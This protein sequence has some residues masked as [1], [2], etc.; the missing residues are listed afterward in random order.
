LAY[1]PPFG[2]AKDPVNLAGMMGQNI[3]NGDVTVAQ[4]SDV[5]GLDPQESFLLDVRQPGE[6]EKGHIPG[7]THIPLP[8][9]RAR[10]HELPEDRE[11]VVSCQSG[12]QAYYACRILSQHGFR[13]QNLTGAYLTWKNG[14][15][16]A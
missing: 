6:W 10:M 14:T 15:D 12:Q 5:A 7:A 16:K 4:W 13:C 2:A 1:A 8:E 11:I 3:L 9:L